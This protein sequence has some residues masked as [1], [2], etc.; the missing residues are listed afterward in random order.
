MVY[1]FSFQWNMPQ[2]VLKCIVYFQINKEAEGNKWNL[3][4]Y[5]DNILYT[6]KVLGTLWYTN[7]VSFS[8]N[9]RYI[10]NEEL[11]RWHSLISHHDISFSDICII[12]WI[13]I[14]IFL[15]AQW[16]KDLQESEY[17]LSFKDKEL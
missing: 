11:F 6:N 3:L 9:N 4:H 10:P 7:T 1:I 16:E 5:K 2:L 8:Y 14:H 15:L 13:M 17:W 12:Y